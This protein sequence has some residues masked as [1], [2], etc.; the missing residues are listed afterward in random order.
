MIEH[1]AQG[2]GLVFESHR[3]RAQ[4]AVGFDTKFAD[5]AGAVAGLAK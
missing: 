5:E 1:T 4:E 3:P 2:F